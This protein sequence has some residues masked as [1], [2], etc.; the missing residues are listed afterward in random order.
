MDIKREKVAIKKQKLEAERQSKEYE[1]Q[2]AKEKLHLERMRIELQ[3]GKTQSSHDGYSFSDTASPHSWMTSY[4]G[5]IGGGVS[6]HDF[7]GSGA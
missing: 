6:E 2:L 4:N 1:F 5:S 3:R 7:T